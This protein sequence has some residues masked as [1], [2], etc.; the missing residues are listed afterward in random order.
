MVFRLSSLPTSDVIAP[1]ITRAN[2]RQF[3]TDNNK[4]TKEKVREH[5]NIL[6]DEKRLLKRLALVMQ[7]EINAHFVTYTQG[8]LQLVASI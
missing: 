6:E 4:V 2:F 7:Q 3:M 8:F 1:V 5:F